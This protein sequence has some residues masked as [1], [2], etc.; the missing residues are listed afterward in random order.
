MIMGEDDDH[1]ND[2][3]KIIDLGMCLSVP[4]LNEK[5]CAVYVERQPMRGK[6]S[7]MAPE[8]FKEQAFEPFKVDIWSAGTILFL[9]LV[10][11]RLYK[12]PTSEDF[13]EIAAG[14]ARDVVDRA[15]EARGVV[16]SEAAK[17]LIASMLHPTPECRVGIDEVLRHPW[18]D[19]RVRPA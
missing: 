8:I 14:R 13:Q 1:E 19:A 18:V 16:I 10:G 9:M 17:D 5:D 3:V 6:L 15:V 12:D 4:E 7:C 2:Q 11:R